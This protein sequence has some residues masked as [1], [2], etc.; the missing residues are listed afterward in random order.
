MIPYPLL[1]RPILN[2]KVWGGGNLAGLGKTLPAAPPLGE[3]WELADLPET[4]PH[5]R[6]IIAHGPL[7]APGLTY[8]PGFPFPAR[9]GR[10]AAAMPQVRPEI[11]KRRAARLRASGDDALNRFLMS[12]IGATADIL[13]ES[14]GTGRS[15]HYAPVSLD[16]A[17]AMGSIVNAVITGVQGGRPLARP[18]P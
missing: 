9:P 8:L 10:P 17:I 4:S 11:R 5:G 14:P 3:S 1:F 18:V 16:P 6:S 2:E 13:V 12:R 7:A 15:E